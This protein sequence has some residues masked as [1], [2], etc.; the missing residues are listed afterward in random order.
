MPRHRL[1]PMPV[2]C[3][4]DHPEAM[5]LPAAAFGMLSRLCLHF[6]ATECRPLPESQDELRSIVRA[7]LRTGGAGNR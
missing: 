2:P 6:W 4:I 1:F 5:A 7:H 3:L